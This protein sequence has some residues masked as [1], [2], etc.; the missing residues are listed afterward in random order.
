[1]KP[2]YVLERVVAVKLQRT[3]KPKS[4][5][6]QTLN[7]AAPENSKVRKN[8]HLQHTL[9]NLESALSDWNQ[10][11]DESKEKSLRQKEMLLRTKNLFLQLKN[12]I[13]DLS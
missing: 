12:Q 7:S 10:M 8:K 3:K 5:A 6:A 13:D 4:R 9:V 2:E 1:L 11:M